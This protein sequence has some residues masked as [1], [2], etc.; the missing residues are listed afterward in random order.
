M[1]KR[2]RKKSLLYILAATCLLL[3]LPSQ[4]MAATSVSG[5]IGSYSVY[6]SLS[7]GTAI[8][9]QS[10]SATTS[11]S[12]TPAAVKATVTYNY[13]F[14]SVTTT[15][16]VSA[17]SENPYSGSVTATATA[18]HTPAVPVSASGTHQVISPPYSW[19]DSTS[20]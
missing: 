13:K 10:A 7:M 8:G 9:T 1:V 16:T 11:I 15:H 18:N 19:S 12:G 5:T 14:G 6:G 3:S 4:A 17:S 20:T 2:N